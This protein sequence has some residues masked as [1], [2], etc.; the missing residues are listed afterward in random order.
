M[1]QKSTFD[2]LEKLKKNNSKEWFDKNRPLYEAARSDVQGFLTKLIA[3][4]AK[5]DNAVK[6][7]IGRAHV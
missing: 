1:I 6:E 3:E 4:T 5:A 2:F 7:Q